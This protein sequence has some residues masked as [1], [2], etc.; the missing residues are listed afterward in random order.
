MQRTKLGL[1]FLSVAISLESCSLYSCPTEAPNAVSFMPAT[2]SRPTILSTGA[3]QSQR[4]A[5]CSQDGTGTRD[6]SST[7]DEEKPVHLEKHNNNNNNMLYWVN[8]ANAELQG[9]LSLHGTMRLLHS[10]PRLLDVLL[11]GEARRLRATAGRRLLSS[12]LSMKVLSV[13]LGNQHSSSSRARIPGGLDE[14]GV[15]EELLQ[16]LVGVV[17][18]Q[19]LE[20]VQ[21]EGS[22]RKTC[23]MV[24]S[25]PAISRMPMNDAPWRLVR[26]RAL[27]MRW[28]SQ[29][30]RRSYVALANASTAKS[31]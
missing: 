23:V 16:L 20:G 7:E 28:T 25:K 14:H 13:A 24:I 11:G 19:L 1:V 8:I 2:W 18:A 21:L 22:V 3:M 5:Q 29:R 10:P 31:A 30:N 17:D 6:P 9:I 15:V 12:T 26:S 4:G 27:L